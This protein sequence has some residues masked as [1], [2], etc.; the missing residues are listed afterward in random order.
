VS[1]PDIVSICAQQASTISDSLVKTCTLPAFATINT[2]LQDQLEKSFSS[3][4]PA[5]VQ[6]AIA[7]GVN[8]ALAG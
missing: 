2:V 7:D 5:S 1:R 3:D 8:T 6:Q 4:D